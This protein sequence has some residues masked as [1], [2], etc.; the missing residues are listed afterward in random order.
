[1]Y[2]AGIAD[3]KAQAFT[4]VKAVEALGRLGVE[5]ARVKV[6]LEGE[7]EQYSPHLPAFAAS[8]GDLLGADI[9]LGADGEAHEAGPLVALGLKGTL[10][11]KL[12][13]ATAEQA[14][15]NGYAP[16][17]PNAIW[18][19]VEVVRTIRD[20]HGTILINGFYDSIAAITPQE[21]QTLSRIPYDEDRLLRGLG[22]K[23][24]LTDEDVD[25]Y[26]RLYMYP[27]ATIAGIQGGYVGQGVKN[28]LPQKAWATIDFQIMPNQTCDEIE[29]KLRRHMENHGFDDVEITV[30][31]KLGHHRIPVG[32]PYVKV[33]KR[34]LTRTYG[35]EPI[36]TPC[37]RG[38]G[39]VGHEFVK[40]GIPVIWI[41]CLTAMDTNMHGVDEHVR[42][43]DVLNGIVAK[44][45]VCNQFAGVFDPPIG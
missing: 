44:A 17:V 5:S 26:R 30:L 40:I 8:H 31:Q 9:L 27:A 29:A 20:P 23:W 36:V 11:V 13:V 39:G 19:L 6:L 3:D 28:V 43:D 45:V 14:M 38:A 37:Y 4:I 35:R 10:F 1:M 42:I 15:P 7:E 22:A 21:E 16:V 34:G 33:V 24:L 12:E 18:R 25:Y 2:G 32:H 41:P